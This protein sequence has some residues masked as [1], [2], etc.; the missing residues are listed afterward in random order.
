MIEGQ[1]KVERLVPGSVQLP[2]NSKNRRLPLADQ[3]LKKTDSIAGKIGDGKRSAQKIPS[4]ELPLDIS[5]DMP[6]HDLDNLQRRLL[7]GLGNDR[8]HQPLST[9]NGPANVNVAIS[10]NP[11]TV[12]HRIELG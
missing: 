7:I 1:G 9:I 6:L 5:I 3:R 2:A 10:P 8:H 12:M 4:P 11:P